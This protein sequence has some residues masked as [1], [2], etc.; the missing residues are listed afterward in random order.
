ML[1]PYTAEQMIH[2]LGLRSREN[3]TTLAQSRLRMACVALRLEE[4]RLRPP[5]FPEGSSRRRPKVHG[6]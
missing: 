5:K 3:A 1:Y 4:F 6:G 2:E